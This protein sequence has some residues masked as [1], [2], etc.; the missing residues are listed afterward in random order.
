MASVGSTP[1]GGKF[2]TSPALQKLVVKLD[3]K[4]SLGLPV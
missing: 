4:R 1:T 2:F 3:V